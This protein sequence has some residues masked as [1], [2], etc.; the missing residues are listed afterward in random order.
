[1]T[2]NQ[3]NACVQ[4]RELLGYLT[5]HGRLN[6]TCGRWFT[7]FKENLLPRKGRLILL[8]C[9][10][11]ICF[12]DDDRLTGVLL[13]FLERHTES[14]PVIGLG[15]ERFYQE[16]G[17]PKDLPPKIAKIQQA[18]CMP[19]TRALAALRRLTPFPQESWSPHGLIRTR[20]QHHKRERRAQCN[21]IRD[22]CGNPWKEPV[23]T[24]DW[25]SWC[26]WENDTILNLT[27]EIYA[28]EAYHKIP[29]LA[30]ALEEA[31]CCDEA[32]LTHCRSSSFDHSRGCWVLDNLLGFER[33]L[34]IDS[35][36]HSNI[37]G[38][39]TV[40]EPSTDIHSPKEDVDSPWEPVSSFLNADGLTLSASQV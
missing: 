39:K 19:L 16:F 3:W 4:P 25:A 32:I 40:A 6:G 31:G 9:C 13:R 27:K 37:D 11:R 28:K 14:P 12:G 30:D 36:L 15:T 34:A 20:K 8:A 1:M 29:I 7:N 18:V 38:L 21:I 5:L 35:D 23:P 10:R 22:V 2:E 24:S 17:M 26:R 33:P